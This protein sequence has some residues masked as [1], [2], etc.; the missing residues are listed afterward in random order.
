MTDTHNQ[1]N[2]NLA[3]DSPT[4][5]FTI[6]NIGAPALAPIP[7]TP[8][9]AAMAV[10]GQ[11]NIYT[12]MRVF[13]MHYHQI[14]DGSAG[15]SNFEIYRRRSGVFTRL[16]VLTLAFGGGDFAT[17]FATPVGD[18][19]VLNAGDYLFCQATSFQTNGDGITVDIHYDPASVVF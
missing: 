15:T 4:I 12:T 14:E 10:F 16:V 13:V 9:A 18:L 19:A 6:G 5:H 7:G 11:L 1:S 17:A 3:P 2:I 8:D